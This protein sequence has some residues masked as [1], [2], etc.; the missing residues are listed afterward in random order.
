MSDYDV[1]PQYP[2][3]K[4]LGNTLIR[5]NL[6]GFATDDQELHQFVLEKMTLI[7]DEEVTTIIYSALQP[8]MNINLRQ[9][10]QSL[11]TVEPLFSNTGGE[12]TRV[13]NE[14]GNYSLINLF[15]PPNVWE[16]SAD[17]NFNGFTLDIAQQFRSI[18]KPIGNIFADSIVAITNCD[19][20]KFDMNDDMGWHLRTVNIPMGVE[21][22]RLILK[23]KGGAGI[24]IGQID[25]GT[26]SHKEIDEDLYDKT[27]QYNTVP[28]ENPND[29]T[30]RKSPIGFTEGHG[31]ST[32]AVLASRGDIEEQFSGKQ[33]ITGVANQ[34]RVVPVRAGRDVV[35]VGAANVAR[36]FEYLI[37]QQVDI[38]TISMGGVLARSFLERII[39][40]AVDENIIVI[41]AGGQCVP[42]IPAPAI[43]HNCIAVTAIDDKDRIWDIATLGG[44]IAIAAPGVGVW[45]PAIEKNSYRQ[46]CGTSF[47]T[48]IVAGTAALWLGECG[49]QRLIDNYA[50][51]RKLQD[52]FREIIRR[53]CRTP[54]DW[55]KNRCGTGIIDAKSVIDT[56]LKELEEKE[57][58]ALEKHL[59]I[60]VEA[61]PLT[62]I[63][64]SMSIETWLYYAVVTNGDN[65]TQEEF[66]SRLHSFI[67]ASVNNAG[68]YLPADDYEEYAWQLHHLLL[69]MPDAREVLRN[70]I[71]FPEAGAK[72]ME[73]DESLRENVKRSLSSD[74]AR[75]F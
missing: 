13:A 21:Q 61:M 62:E 32:A 2:S 4:W 67:T 19:L 33:Y 47:A 11:V 27:R 36:A 56:T 75:I 31:G 35:I 73:A 14:L 53:C 34:A 51:G 18:F 64:G 6:E 55:D 54:V 39:D 44:A 3:L 38:I 52:V 16:G 7:S 41:V 5:R 59:E 72:Y 69:S 60:D 63:E 30:E 10:Y 70:D 1:S 29:A 15:L 9:S 37:E 46:S 50:N 48:P 28:G 26:R 58:I 65:L 49:K 66:S 8:D 57:K 12:A 20:E 40:V 23:H 71:L 68:E 42:F 74:L 43:Y 17:K 22:G 25:T 24:V 45:I